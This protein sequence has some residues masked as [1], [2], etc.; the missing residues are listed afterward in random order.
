MKRSH[1]IALI[2]IAISA[3]VIISMVN[4]SIAYGTFAEASGKKGVEFHIVGTLDKDMPMEYDP[5][6]DPN[7]FTFY[8][9][10]QDLESSK[11]V[12]LDTKPQDFENA[13]QVVV[14]G[15]MKDDNFHAYR[16]L[17]KCPSKY[18]EEDVQADPIQN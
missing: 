1:I 17:R 5:E 13:E 18:I 4:E 2:F 9:K 3:A 6:V 12:Y 7:Y 8:M 11:I 15:S 16:I 10:D 14:V